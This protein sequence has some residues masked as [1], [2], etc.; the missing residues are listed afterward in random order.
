MDGFNFDD[1]EDE[2]EILK[3]NDDDEIDIKEFE[4]DDEDKKLSS[5]NWDDI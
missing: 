2:N 3:E 4:S 5:I 1:Y